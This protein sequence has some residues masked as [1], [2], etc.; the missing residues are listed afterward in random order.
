MPC[1]DALPRTFPFGGNRNILATLKDIVSPCFGLPSPFPFGGNRNLYINIIRKNI[2]EACQGLSRSEGI[3]TGVP[4]LI[5]KDFHHLPRT[6]PFG[7]NRN[8]TP[9][10][11][12]GSVLYKGLAEPFPVRRESKQNTYCPFPSVSTMCLHVLS[13]LEGI[14][15]TRASRRDC[16]LLPCPVLSRLEGIETH[17]AESVVQK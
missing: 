4:L 13:R 14:E 1:L 6:F 2:D 15:T 9:A 5:L 8:N 11:S 12:D 17:C 10:A 7:G 16:L 3:E